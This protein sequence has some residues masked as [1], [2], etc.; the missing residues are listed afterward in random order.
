MN[1]EKYRSAMDKIKADQ[2]YQEHLVDTMLNGGAKPSH[3]K[4]WLA[5]ALA[6]CGLCLCVVLGYAFIK[7]NHILIPVSEGTAAQNTASLTVSSAAAAEAGAPETAAGGAGA[8]PQAA[9]QGSGEADQS[10]G[11]SSVEIRTYDG[12]TFIGLQ[13]LYVDGKAY[14]PNRFNLNW[15]TNDKCMQFQGDYAGNV[16]RDLREPQNSAADSWSGYYPVGSKV[17]NVEGMAEGSAYLIVQPDGTATVTELSS[18]QEDLTFQE[19][20]DL[21]ILE[22]E[23]R[24]TPST[25]TAV[26]E[27]QLYTDADSDDFTILYDETLLRMLDEM[28]E[29]KPLAQTTATPGQPLVLHFRDGGRAVT[30]VNLQTNTLELLGKEYSLPIGFSSS[31]AQAVEKAAKECRTYSLKELLGYPENLE[32]AGI[33]SFRLAAL[34]NSGTPALEG[35][36]AEAGELA[37]AF[38]G[39]V[40]GRYRFYNPVGLCGNTEINQAYRLEIT[41]GGKT[42]VLEFITLDGG[43][44]ALV[45][46]NGALYDTNEQW[47][48]AGEIWQFFTDQSQ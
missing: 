37:E 3:A 9:A 45:K 4:A 25:E 34:L 48:S 26:Y 29:E 2:K 10:A 32:G 43:D 44:T 24:G 28:K 15:N 21:F 31:C 1:K 30:Y 7:D 40:L 23:E 16:K 39:G 27:A 19:A 38:L 20:V 46:I 18:V 6:V 47:L 12:G 42:D 36:G 14:E 35:D 13:T 17:Y 5:P 22:R 11:K 33:S 41:R 8:A